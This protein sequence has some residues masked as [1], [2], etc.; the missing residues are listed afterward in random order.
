MQWSIYNPAL[1]QSGPS[2]SLAFTEGRE[3]GTGD[4]YIHKR[5]APQHLERLA[6]HCSNFQPIHPGGSFMET[7]C[8]PHNWSLQSLR[9]T[10][11]TPTPA[12]KRELHSPSPNLWFSLL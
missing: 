6:P 11:P 1:S 10:V 12:F 2:S 7:P 3:W 4:L 5:S 8:K 9:A